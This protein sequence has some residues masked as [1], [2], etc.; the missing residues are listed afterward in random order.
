MSK[1]IITYTLPLV[2]GAL[3]DSM[4]AAVSY[5][6]ESPDNQKHLPVTQYRSFLGIY[7][8]LWD[9][10]HYRIEGMQDDL[11]MRSC[12]NVVYLPRKTP[13]I[14]F[15]DKGNYKT[16]TIHFSIDFLNV[17][18]ADF[19]LL[20][21][22]LDNVKT[23]KP[24]FLCPH[25]VSITTDIFT[26]I[27]QILHNRMTEPNR[28]I[29]LRGKIFEIL[30]LCLKEVKS[31]ITKTNPN[32]EVARINQVHDFILKNLKNHYSL[33]FLANMAEMDKRK[34]EKRFKM[35]YGETVYHFYLEARLKKAAMLLSDT[36]LT[37]KEIGAAVGFK[38]ANKFT[39]AFKKQYG[40]SPIEFRKV[41]SRLQ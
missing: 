7:F 5:F 20:S 11:I 14:Y 15:L 25:H 4:K 12:F 8:N 32:K 22:L 27:L 36:E 18:K 26:I 29:Y 33:D 16:L 40:S 30:G 24:A 6:A 3:A 31:E 21:K 41:A 37:A 38:R 35:I 9:G 39:E 19:P 23:N 10:I 13:V 34:L 17:W 1:N 28:K 2:D